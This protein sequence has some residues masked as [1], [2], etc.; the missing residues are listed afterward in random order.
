MTALPPAPQDIREPA[1][2][3]TLGVLT[4]A[5]AATALV[6]ADPSLLARFLAPAPSPPARLAALA[7]TALDHRSPPAA[8]PLD[9]AWT[10]ALRT[11]VVTGTA[12][13]TSPDLE[14]AP[15][16]DPRGVSWLAL[17]R[18]PVPLH[19]PHRGS[20]ACAHLVDAV[21][22]AYTASG[23]LAAMYTGALAGARWGLSAVPLQALRVLAATT[24]PHTLLADAALSLEPRT[25]RW[26][27]DSVLATEPRRLPPF[28]V[29]HPLD[30]GVLLGNID[31][32]RARPETVD[33]VVSLCRTHPTDAPHLA[34]ADWI[35][36]WL[37]DSPQVNTNLHFTLDEAAA[38]VAALR[39]EGKRVLVHCWAGASRT[40]AVAARYAAAGLGAPVLP[41]LT[42]LI[43]TVGGHLDN[44]ALARAVAHLSGHDLADPAA[45][46]FPDGI[47]PRRADLPDPRITG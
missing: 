11:L 21:W 5:A 15:V 33:A 18:T 16:D 43:R 40:P 10:D 9:R 12:P 8:D 25:D 24:D 4:G 35:R 23:D 42:L 32:L 22:T 30:P 45:T 46:L 34:P 17:T 28:A 37:H 1:W 27:H 13:D 38:A 47:P 19:A 41:A 26:P 29:P 20:F 2:D 7:R 31:H 36:V 6:G 44:P 14:H 39:A 3:R